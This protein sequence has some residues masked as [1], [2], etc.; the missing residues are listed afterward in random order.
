MPESGQR[1]EYV[2]RL[3]AVDRYR[4]LH[5]RSGKRIVFFRVQLETLIERE[6]FPV[7]RYDTAHG[8]AHRDLMSRHGQV[9]KT[10]GGNNMTTLMPAWATSAPP[11]ML[12]SEFSS[13]FLP[14]CV[15]AVAVLSVA[16]PLAAERLNRAVVVVD[17]PVVDSLRRLDVNAAV[18]RHGNI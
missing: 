9:E 8:F 3:S 15:P 12:P 11:Y 16:D 17:P 2:V 18:E 6:W 7:V 10:L 14:K 5:V 1:T 13:C 4:H